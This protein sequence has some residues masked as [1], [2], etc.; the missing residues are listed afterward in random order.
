MIRAMKG[1]IARLDF[2]IIVNPANTQLLP[3]GGVNKKIF[4]Q[5]GRGMLNEL[6]TMKEQKAGNAV[7]SKAYNLPCRAVIHAVAPVFNFNRDEEE[8]LLASCY[9][10]V[11][12]LSYHFMRQENL[13]KLTLGIPPLG[14]GPYGFPADQACAIGVDTIRE[15]FDQYPDARVI[16]V[17][18]VC[19][20][21]EDY[22]LYK[23][24]L[25]R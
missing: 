19:E 23:E 6:I 16:D 10:N 25:A 20:K 1:D 13:E 7:L 14:T 17:T 15:L 4:E 5:A 24:V 2:D 21:Q 18:F 11:L 9:W 3:G 22:R 12:R 8:D